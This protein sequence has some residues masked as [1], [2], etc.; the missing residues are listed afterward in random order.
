METAWS[1]I[2]SNDI[3]KIYISTNF[4]SVQDAEDYLTY[5]YGEADSEDANRRFENEQSDEQTEYRRKRSEYIQK[6]G[7]CREIN[8]PDSHFIYEQK[9]DEC[10]KAIGDFISGLQ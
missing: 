3:P 9:P 4:S 6:L 5:V 1:S 2:E 7:N 10:A 8:I